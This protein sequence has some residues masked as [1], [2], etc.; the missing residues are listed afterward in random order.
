MELD[1]MRAFVA[2]ADLLSFTR[3]AEQLHLS[4]S[5]LSRRIRS[6]EDELGTRLFDRTTRDVQLT[7]AGRVLYEQATA[8]LD[9][10]LSAVEATRGAAEGTG[11][12][13]IGFG[14]AWH[15][16]VPAVVRA[17]TERH[18]AVTLRIHTGLTTTAHIEQLLSRRIDVGVIPLPTG[19]RPQGLRTVDVGRHALLVAVS[20]DDPLGAHDEVQ[21]GELARTAFIDY[22]ASTM[23]IV[24]SALRAIGRAGRFEPDIRFTADG[25]QTHLALVAAGLAASVV[26]A[27]AIPAGGVTGVRVL[28]VPTLDLST[29]SALAFSELDRNPLI[30]AYLE[31]T[32]AALET[33]GIRVPSQVTKRLYADRTRSASSGAAA[34]EG[35]RRS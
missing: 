16:V 19:S 30:P 23:P 27:S 33:L 6:L 17:F 2:V 20:A 22:P 35:H 28:E 5:P 11:S 4:Q 25:V 34:R 15:T 26:P 21:P 29:N 7:P 32:R 13:S 10:Y 12:L 1:R 3:A 14:E 31:C 24:H 9:S 8:L 18:P